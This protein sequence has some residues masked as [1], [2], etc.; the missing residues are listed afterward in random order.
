MTDEIEAITESAKAGQEIA[1]ATAQAIAAGERF[2]A[3]VARFISGPLEQ[4][5]G[6]VEDRLKYFRWERQQRLIQ[7]SEEF[8]HSL[9]MGGPT[10]AVPLKIAIPLL[11][12]ASL[13]DDD[14][15]QDLWAKLLV[16]AADEDNPVTI[17]RMFI[18]ILENIGP[19]EA[20]ILD[21]IYAIPFDDMKHRGV[22]TASLPRS[23]AL[24]HKAEGYKPKDPSPDVELALAN[25]ARLGCLSPVKTFG[26]GEIL[27]IINP[28]LLGKSFVEAC[29][30][31]TRAS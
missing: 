5:S 20:R 17:Q 11:Q 4:A 21:A 30:L 9:G 24:L 25:L 12:G 8:M 2:G 26:G 3:F 14:T 6:I 13:E 23:A 27:A 31:R 15:L 28:S 19:L 29:T 10:R 16:N 7:R 18:D 22:E 1:K